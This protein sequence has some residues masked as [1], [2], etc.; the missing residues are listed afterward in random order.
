MQ[1]NLGLPQV[2]TA[3]DIQSFLCVSKGKAYE[4]F[5]QKDFPTL[6]I[7]GTKRVLKDDFLNW[8]EQQ[9]GRRN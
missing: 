1:N 6:V 8:I 4:I 3:K 2:L 9:K 5:K 7:G